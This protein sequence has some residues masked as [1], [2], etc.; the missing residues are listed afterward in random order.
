MQPRFLSA[1]TN[2][3]Y[4]QPRR[5]PTQTSMQSSH[6]LVHHQSL[7]GEDDELADSPQDFGRTLP[8]VKRRRRKLRCRQL[9]RRDVADAAAAD[10]VEAEVANAE[11]TT[12]R[13]ASTPPVSRAL[14]V[15]EPAADADPA[16]VASPQPTPRRPPPTSLPK[17]RCK[18]ATD[19]QERHVPDDWNMINVP[20]SKP[21]R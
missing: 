3:A 8:Q 2:W 21:V 13:R 1:V 18:D 10:A 11:R 16:D 5:M 4:G 15:A 12:P 20:R 7:D 6:N 17:Q 9:L 14:G 19:D